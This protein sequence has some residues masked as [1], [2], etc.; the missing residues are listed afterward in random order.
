M[1]VRGV[2]ANFGIY[3]SPYTFLIPVSSRGTFLGIS[4]NVLPNDI[5][6]VESIG[7]QQKVSNIMNINVTN[8]GLVPLWLI[9]S[10]DTGKI[11]CFTNEYSAKQMADHISYD[12]VGRF[13]E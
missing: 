6:L 2:F 11:S 8:E 9:Y 1:I 10:F 4:F 3:G 13:H 7:S 5:Y 12:F